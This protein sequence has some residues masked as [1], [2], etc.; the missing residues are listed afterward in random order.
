MYKQNIMIAVVCWPYAWIISRA[1]WPCRFCEA[2]VF[3]FYRLLLDCRFDSS[4]RNHSAKV[5]DP[6][7]ALHALLEEKGGEKKAKKDSANSSLC[8]DQKF[9]VKV[10]WIL[11]GL[12]F[13][14][15]QGKPLWHLWCIAEWDYVCS[16]CF[17][18]ELSISNEQGTIYLFAFDGFK[19]PTVNH[20]PCPKTI[21]RP[22]DWIITEFAHIV[23]SMSCHHITSTVFFLPLAL[24]C[25]QDQASWTAFPSPGE[26]VWREEAK[27]NL[28]E[29]QFVE[30]IEPRGWL[31]K[32]KTI[33]DK[34]W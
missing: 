30:Q 6:L 5:K 26:A 14:S 23:M 9:A 2:N 18:K 33:D 25:L 32:H 13:V 22:S 24:F 20:G 17:W 16:W 10:M 19:I 12:E 4:I 31:L 3:F 1:A 11:K 21:V 15:A 7:K 27:V 34:W 29:C 8:Q 28:S